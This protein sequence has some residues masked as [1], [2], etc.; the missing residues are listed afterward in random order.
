MAEERQLETLIIGAG[1]TGLLVAQGLKKAGLPFRIFEYESPSTYQTRPREW[2]MTL[3]WGSEHVS[4][5][6]PPE[7]VAR[8]SETYA[9]PTVSPD[10]VTGL[11]IFNGKTGEQIVEMKAEKPVRVSRKKLRNLFSEGVA[12]EYGKEVVDIQE[13]EVEEGGVKREKVRVVFK[14]GTD[15]VG[16]LVVGCD[17]ARSRA[18][19]CIVGKEKAELTDV[20]LSMFNFTSR[21][22]AEQA[23]ELRK[24][25]PLFINAIHPDHGTMFWIS[26]QD[27]PDPS[28]P[29]TWLFQLLLSW[30]HNPL[31]ASQNTQEGRM[32]F[33]KKRA[34]EYA[35][36]W[37][38]AGEWVKEDCRIPMDPGT[39]WGKA[40]R[41]DN[42]GGRMTIAG[43]A[44]H[45]M[46]PH[47]GQGLNNAL[48]D[49]VHFSSAVALAA[50]GTKTLKEAI[51][52]YDKEVLERGMLEMQISLKQTMFIH[53]WETLMASPMV[54]LGMRQ[55]KKEEAEAELNGGQEE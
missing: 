33:F 46:T 9:D 14:D 17:G 30:T 1:T 39:Y 26:I 34:S 25:N 47:R 16:D 44:A 5:V 12:V 8:M 10:A 50:S 45:P 7:L 22:T 29:S 32:A 24:L 54:K 35:E 37:R 27:A 43:D 52:D 41:W 31:P 55:A 20:P 3:H 38:S 28:D 18:R 19:E 42:R 21:F 13:A 40:E 23:L 53:N 49:A 36:P 11:P 48:Q 51:D 15:A 6:L 4:K 2:G